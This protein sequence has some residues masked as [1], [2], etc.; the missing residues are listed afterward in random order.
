MPT[1]VKDWGDFEVSGSLRATPYMRQVIWTL[2]IPQSF[3]R[4]YIPRQTIPTLR[5]FS[6]I[7]ES[8]TGNDLALRSTDK[9]A[10]IVQ[11]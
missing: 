5:R 9:K 6:E 7:L 8:Y 4:D 3:V 1:P 10:N 11:K 2:I